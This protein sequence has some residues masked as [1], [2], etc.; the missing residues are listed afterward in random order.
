METMSLG[1]QTHPGRAP[2]A[3]PPAPWRLRGWGFATCGLVEVTAARRFVPPEATVVPVW[4]GNMIGGVYFASYEEGSALVYHELIISAALV[5]ICGRLCFWMPRLYVDS[6]ESLAAGHA[7]WGV[8]KELATFSVARDGTERVV[9]V[10]QAGELVCRLRAGRVGRTV[11]GLLPLPAVGVGAGDLRF[12]TG[13]LAGRVARLRVGVEI[14][15]TS[16]FA[17]LRLDRPWLGLAHERLHL[18]VPAPR[19]VPRPPSGARR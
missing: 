8:P 15:A 2:T 11:P 19:I 6:A 9:T 18:L 7:I 17:P 1:Q 12:F 13:R 16:P 10:R 3:Y 14:P 5:W 4:P